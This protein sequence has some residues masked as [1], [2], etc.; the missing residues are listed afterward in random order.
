VTIDH[1][2]RRL[3]A[4]VCS[5]A[6]MSRIVDPILADARWEDGRVT[7]RGAAALV[8]ALAVYAFTSMP[9]WAV[10]VWADD[11]HAMPKA[12]AFIMTTAILAAVA[13]I[14]L[15]LARVPKPQVLSP[16]GLAVTLLPQALALTLPAS[17]L[18]AVPL[19]LRRV[20]MSGRLI[21]RT[22][23]L[24]TAVVAANFV[25][26]VYAIPDANQSFREAVARALPANAHVNLSRG[27]MEMN[28]TELRRQ[29]ADLKRTGGGASARRLEY[30]YQVRLGI[31]AAAIPLALAGLAV[32]V[33][34]SG[35][36]RVLLAIGILV[37]Y[38]ALMAYE[39]SAV[40]ALI[41]SGGFFPEYFCAWTPNAILLIVAATLLSRRSLNRPWRLPAGPEHRT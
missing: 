14:A 18:V 16:V 34:R 20:Q 4:R 37:A 5:D 33:P 26:V 10:G 19:A 40:Q 30:T 41:N 6:T 22:L 2:L 21:R 29:I 17:L 32:A 24:S 39:K 13:L 35:S 9:S 12:A 25:V 8:K 31:V 23:L 15:P 11:G 27:P 28:L 1:P 38:W 3:L 7:V 36:R